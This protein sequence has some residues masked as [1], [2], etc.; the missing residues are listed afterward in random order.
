MEF[1]S[2]NDVIDILQSLINDENTIQQREVS[3]IITLLSKNKNGLSP[4][5]LTKNIISRQSE[6]GAPIG[7]SKDGA[8]SIVEK[9][10]Y[11]RVEEILKHLISNA[12][13]KIVIPPGTPI[14]GQGVGADGVPVIVTGIVS[15]LATG[16]GVIT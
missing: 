3:S 12:K 8:S 16:Y 14:T 4:R 13:I 11:I 1:F 5:E 10:E 7:P 15:G 9:M 2:T 6:A